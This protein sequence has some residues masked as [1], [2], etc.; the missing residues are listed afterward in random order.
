MTVD[1]NVTKRAVEKRSDRLE[2][3]AYVGALCTRSDALCGM[4]GYLQC[5]CVV[6]VMLWYS[7]KA[8]EKRCRAQRPRSSALYK[9]ADVER[10]QKV[11]VTRKPVL[12]Q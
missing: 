2:T 7:A 8:C 9:L 10:S 3:A 4:S 5:T 11:P 6:P 12:V 1:V